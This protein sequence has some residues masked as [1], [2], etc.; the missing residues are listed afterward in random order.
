MIKS[1][2]NLDAVNAMKLYKLCLGIFVV[3]LCCVQSTF[4]QVSNSEGLSPI[5]GVVIPKSQTSQPQA[6]KPE[7]FF[8][9][10]DDCPEMVVIPA[11]SFLMGSPIDPEH[12]PASNTTPPKNGEDNERPQHRI[13]I[14]AFA[15]GEYEVT[16]AQWYTVMGNNPSLNKGRTLP[17]GYVSWDDVQLFLHNLIK[18]TGKKYRLPSEAEW[19][20][21]ARGGSTTAYPWGNSLPNNISSLLEMETHVSITGRTNPVGLKKPNQFG[22]YDMIG[23][24]WEWTQD[25]WNENYKGAPTEGSAWTNGDCSQRVLRGGSGGSFGGRYQYFRF[26]FRDKDNT[27][28]RFGSNG[29]RVARDL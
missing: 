8:K 18:K 24:V 12:D 28:I 26:A 29:F 10:C 22:L 3:W 27:A 17:V 15:M 11:G 14:Q 5:E 20:Y 7:A 2:S 1:P 21:A 4:A 9:D 13:Q 25:C 23:S 16:Q 6:V 19:E